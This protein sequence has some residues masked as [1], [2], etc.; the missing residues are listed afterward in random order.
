V[1]PK[2]PLVLKDLAQKVDFLTL[3]E[4]AKNKLA[5]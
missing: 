1:L 4:N 3:T 2:L 5:E